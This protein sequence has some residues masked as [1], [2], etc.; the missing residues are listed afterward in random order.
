[1][2]SEIAVNREHLVGGGEG[3]EVIEG[4]H[5]PVGCDE[6]VDCVGGQDGEGLATGGFG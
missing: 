2:A 6:G 3:R 1:M 4:G 5:D